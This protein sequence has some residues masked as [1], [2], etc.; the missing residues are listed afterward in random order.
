MSDIVNSD[1]LK[2][3]IIDREE[4]IDLIY[5]TA[6]A[7]ASYDRIQIL[8]LLIETP[9]S[10]W[11]ISKK[12][13]MPISSVSNHISILEK[14][15]LIFVSTQQGAKRHVKMCSKQVNE[16]TF[17]L[18]SAA[19]PNQSEAYTT[20]MPVGH[21]IEAN[22]SA[23]CGMYVIRKTDNKE[24]MLS[25]DTP[26]DFFSPKRF[27]AELL[28]FDHGFVSYN[29][30]NK[31]HNKSISK[32]ELSFE[33]CSEVIYHR[34]DWP[35]DISVK[36]NGVDAL[37]FTSPGDYGG[38][39][40]KYSPKNWNINSTQYGQLY[41][42]IVDKEG[43]YLN[44]VLISPKTIDSF[45]LSDSPSIQISLGVKKDALHCGG[46]NLFG[47]KFGDYDRAILLT[48]YS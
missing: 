17:M 22:I 24:E 43:T 41:N 8:R 31:L 45:T 38:R 42:V 39:R 14:S 27:E 2:S 35:S 28:W 48:I 46:L 10:I 40:G 4:D 26:T 6:K 5:N 15:Q 19:I 37:T 16:I 33:L 44:N 11:E 20:E 34:M 47:K 13:N 12:L 36:I 25:V 29:F 21:F 3:L 9:M 32:L 23:P 7:F 30:P 18:Y 1:K